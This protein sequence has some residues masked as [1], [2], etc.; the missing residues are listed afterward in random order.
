MLLRWLLPVGFICALVLSGCSGAREV[1]SEDAA[2]EPVPEPV[3][4]ATPPLPEVDTVAVA[5][6]ADPLGS[7]L[8]AAPFGVEA[9]QGIPEG[10]TLQQRLDSLLVLLNGAGPLDRPVADT[11]AADSTAFLDAQRTLVAA[12]QAQ[13][14]Q[15]STQAQA[16]LTEAQR[17]F[18]EILL[19]DPEHFDA[20]YQLQRIYGIQARRYAGERNW[21]DVLTVLRG[22]IALNADQ[23]RL[24]A[25]VAVVL[26]NLEWHDASALAWMRAAAVVR[27]D[28]GMAAAS[29]VPPL[30]SLSLFTYYQRAYRDFALVRDGAGVRAA[31]SQAVTFAADSTQHAYAVSE[32]AWARWDG[33]N[34]GHRLAFDSL[35]TLA[36]NDPEAALAGL[37]ELMDRVGQHSALLEVAYNHAILSWQEG[38]HDQ[39]L[40]TLQALWGRTDAAKAMPYEE[41]AADLLDTYAS[42]LFQ[43]GL[44][45]RQAGA[46]ARAFT[47][48]L[49]VTAL[50]SRY[51]GQAYIEAL[52]LTR[53][54]PRQARKLA[55][56]IEAVYDSLTVDDRRTYLS[57]LG[58]FYRRIG[59]AETAKT[60]LDRYQALVG[61]Q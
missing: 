8:V 10:R 49:M 30:D 31:L 28:S 4:I 9:E 16:L 44:Q 42:A 38:W 7:T 46:S 24:W 22:L 50:G 56:Q 60:Y 47:Y 52:R 35:Q 21:S 15:D 26:Q 27:D 53:N 36:A 3:E 12:A 14:R 13:D 43:R 1:A 40:D 54:N 51:T 6:S 45:H 61:V 58:S 41:F 11:S 25:E 2:P 5:L 17:R 18:E 32:L 55:P 19:H 33:R 59:D 34:F 29:Q 37:A 20:R 39:A 57:L 23:H 48:L